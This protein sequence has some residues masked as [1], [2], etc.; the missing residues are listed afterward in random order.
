MT[1]INCTADWCANRR[2]D[3]VCAVHTVQLA[4]EMDGSPPLCQTATESLRQKASRLVGKRC[5]VWTTTSAPITGK[6]IGHYN[7]YLRLEE[8]ITYTPLCETITSIEEV[9]PPDSHVGE[10]VTRRP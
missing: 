1:E 7:H 6:L 8:H 10:P 4:G 2:T 5:R 3:G 9:C